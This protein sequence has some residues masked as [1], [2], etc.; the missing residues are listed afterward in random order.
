MLCLAHIC[1]ADNS[2]LVPMSCILYRWPE[3]Y[4]VKEKPENT[5]SRETGESTGD[6]LSSHLPSKAGWVYRPPEMMEG[7]SFDQALRPKWRKD[8]VTVALLIN[9]HQAN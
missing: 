6:I 8:D 9:G 5:C 2:P 1:R 3:A 4:A 7:R